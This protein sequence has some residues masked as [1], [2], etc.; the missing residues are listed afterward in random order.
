MPDFIGFAC[1]QLGGRI[2]SQVARVTFDEFHRNSASIIKH[3]A[4]GNVSSGQVAPQLKFD[5]NNLVR[6][7]TSHVVIRNFATLYTVCVKLLH[8]SVVFVNDVIVDKRC[9]W[10]GDLEH[11]CAEH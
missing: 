10:S 11:R 2:R 1:S 6:C 5:A 7:M 4:F 3:A 8:F 9:V